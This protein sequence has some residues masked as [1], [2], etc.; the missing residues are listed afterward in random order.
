[1]AYFTGKKKEKKE[2]WPAGSFMEGSVERAG[3]EEVIHSAC[4]ANGPAV[5]GSAVN[6]ST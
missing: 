2:S 1:M 4:L 5:G 6:N 3:V